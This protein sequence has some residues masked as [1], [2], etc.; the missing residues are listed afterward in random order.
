MKKTFIAVAAVLALT[1]GS[2]M[3]GGDGDEELSVSS[4][5]EINNVANVRTCLFFFGF[6]WVDGEAKANIGNEQ[7]TF[8]NTLEPG[9]MKH[10]HKDHGDDP[11]AT[12]GGGALAKASGNIGVNVAAGVG[13]NQSNDVALAAIDADNVFAAATSVSHQKTFG[14]SEKRMTNTAT[15]DGGALAD[16]KGNIGVNIAAGAGNNQEN[17]L[18]ASINKS[19]V[20]A[21]ATGT[22][23][24]TTSGNKETGVVDMATLGGGAL[25]GAVGNIGVNLAAGVGN[26]QHNSLAIAVG[27]KL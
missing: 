23:D 1:A 8:N 15:L 7:L 18:A 16:A 2:A 5:T 14:N 25:A 27:A 3:A 17:A 24:Q 19:G 20:L 13:N 10:H 6:N 12:V 9:K 22:N 21:M 4:N 11:T 26:N